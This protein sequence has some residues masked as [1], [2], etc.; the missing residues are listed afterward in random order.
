[1]KIFKKIKYLIIPII[2]LP[3]ILDFFRLY[4]SLIYDNGYCQILNNRALHLFPSC[5]ANSGAD[6][7]LSGGI[8][9]INEF[10]YFLN[11]INIFFYTRSQRRKKR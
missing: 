1:M 9:I 3:I 5:N 7:F 4:S 10:L 11:F 6:F 2:T 8:I